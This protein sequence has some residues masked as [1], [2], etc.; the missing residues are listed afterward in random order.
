MSD[1]IRD[2]N[3]ALAENRELRERLRECEAGAA[4]MRSALQQACFRLDWFYENRQAG[5]AQSD[6]DFDAIAIAALAKDAGAKLLAEVERL[7][8]GAGQ[9]DRMVSLL[10]D[11]LPKQVNFHRPPRDEGERLLRVL[12]QM[13][14]TS[15]M[16]IERLEQSYANGMTV[17]A[18]WKA[19]L[20]TLR[21][22]VAAAE[23]MAEALETCKRLP[24]ARRY[25]DGPCISKSDH[26]EVCAALADWQEAN[27]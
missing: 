26:E 21:R 1:T 5:K 22:K 25:P 19:E 7:R 20:I 13:D 12:V 9:L 11:H 14:K 6:R 17:E 3:T 2:L 24:I 23:G 27:T 18:A 8:K 10:C 15:D 4:A 16:V